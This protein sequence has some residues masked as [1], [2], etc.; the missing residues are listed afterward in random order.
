M[1]YSKLLIPTVKEVPAEA[2]VPSHQLMLRAGYIRKVASGTYTYL[3]LG[4]RSLRKIMQIVREEIDAAGAQEIIMPIAQPM[5]LW[6]ATGRKDDYG[7]TL[8]HF[9]D[10]HGRDNALA[11][12]AEEV[13]TF[14]ASHEI[15]SYKQLPLNLYQINTKYRD[16]FR[17]RFGVLR[18]REFIMKDAY[19]F[20]AD[21]ESLDQSYRAMYDAY[22]RIL[23]RCGVPYVI[24]EAA[25]GEIG[26][27]GSH[28]FM[29]PCDAGEDTILAS[30][31]GNY[32]ANVEKCAIGEREATLDGEPTGELE[33]VHTPELKSIDDVGAFMKVKPKH[34]LKTLVFRNENRWVIGVV[35][36]DH[37]LSEDKFNALVDGPV[38]QADEND[39]ISAGFTIGFVG[40]HAV[41]GRD[42][43]TMY[44]DPD[45]AAAQ[46][47]AGGA[48]EKD[49]HVKHF[50]WRRDVLAPLGEHAGQVVQIADIRSALDGD[51]SPVN[52]GGVLHG[53]KGIETGH[54]FKLGTK[55]SEKLGATF[56]DDHGTEH[57]CLMGCYGI[58][59]NRILAAAIE[60]GYD[61]DGCV[62]P[63]TIAPFEVEIVAVGSGDN[64]AAESERLYAGLQAAGVDV[65]L[66]DRAARPGVKF[67]D[68]DLIGMPLQVV[69]GDRGLKDGAVEVKRRAGGAKESVPLGDVIGRVREIL[70]E[71]Y[72]SPAV[73]EDST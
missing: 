6:E 46:F 25:S 48:N 14:H 15:K 70:A 24:V 16:E 29:I 21:E 23:T 17:P 4:A 52:D 35:R 8:G 9:I 55:Y 39:A 11:P 54:I 50:N 60:V 56:L 36:G 45:A 10:R 69:V 59:I 33:S 43:V 42:D 22:C 73:A 62:L 71:M 7:E 63:V 3:V 12:T 27:T 34:L 32:A 19:S 20:D 18:S 38:E 31:K 66:D 49:H 53:S 72:A 41:V 2:E 30:D 67:K 5:E 58:G 47:W 1:R 44:V 37:E 28:E 57:P 68:A 26:G 64:V 40:P 51:P 13:C 65:L 61:E